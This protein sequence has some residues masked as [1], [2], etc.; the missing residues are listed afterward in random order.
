MQARQ[1]A[2]VQRD[3]SGATG[4][5]GIAN[6]L[7]GKP[8]GILGGDLGASIGEKAA[9]VAQGGAELVGGPTQLLGNTPGPR[10]QQAEAT[11]TTT[12]DKIARFVGATGPLAPLGAPGVLASR[13][14]RKSVV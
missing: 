6:P 9:N 4:R 11:P 7:T 3:F 2:A 13:G 14:D 5:Q 8:T 12:G 10:Y 1:A